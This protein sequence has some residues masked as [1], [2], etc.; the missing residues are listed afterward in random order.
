MTFLHYQDYFYNDNGIFYMKKSLKKNN[1]GILY[2]I[3]NFFC[4]LE[5]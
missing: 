5:I 4:P 3:N 1:N 2:Y